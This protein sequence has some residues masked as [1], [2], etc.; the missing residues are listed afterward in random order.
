MQR[1]TAAPPSV[2]AQIFKGRKE[3]D[4]TR[5]K[6]QLNTDTHTHVHA[7]LGAGDKIKRQV[8]HPAS[9]FVTISSSASSLCA[10][11]RHKAGSVLIRIQLHTH[12]QTNTQ[13]HTH[14]NKHT[15]THTDTHTKQRQLLCANSL[16]LA[17][18]CIDFLS[19]PLKVVQTHHLSVS[20]NV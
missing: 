17:L 5:S 16:I 18:L 11:T 13:T 9:T 2:E 6:G 4:S 15:D 20:A 19:L 12:T 3:H 8:S 7:L 14:A 1:R 10:R